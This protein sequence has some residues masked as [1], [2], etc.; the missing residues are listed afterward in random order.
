LSYRDAINSDLK[1]IIDQWVAIGR[2][3]KGSNIHHG[4]R[5]VQ[6]QRKEKRRGKTTPAVLNKGIQST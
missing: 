2:D 3:A 6:T 5:K 4:P 1:L